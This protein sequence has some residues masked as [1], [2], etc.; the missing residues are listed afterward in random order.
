MSIATMMCILAAP[1][2]GTVLPNGIVLPPVWPPVIDEQTANSAT[3]PYLAS[4]PAVIPIDVGRQ[5]LVDDFLIEHTTL[6]RR[7]HTAELHPASPVLEPGEPWEKAGKWKQ[8][9]GPYAIPFSDGVWFDPADRLFKMWYMGGLL[10]ST[11]LAT[12]TDGIHW[13]RPKLDVKAGTNIVHPGNRDACT[14]WLDLDEP[15]PARRYK[16]F[17]FQKQPRRGLVLHYSADGIHWGGEAAWAGQCH[18]RTTV[19]YNPFRKV[20]ACSIKATLPP[21]PPYKTRVRRYHEGPDPAAAMNWCGYGDPPLWL[22]A[23]RPNLSDPGATERAVVYNLDAVAYESLMLGLFSIIEGPADKAAGRP[24]R[25]QVF[26]G[27]S[28]D[29]FHWYRPCEKPLYGVSERRG[30]WNW[31]NVQSAGGC[32][33]IVGDR[34][35]FYHSGRAGN[36]RLGPEQEFWDADGSTGLA[37]LRRDGF[38]SM[39]A[40][41]TDR[42]LTTRPLRF[43]GAHLFVNAA[44]DGGALRVEVLDADGQAIGPYTRAACEPFTGDSTLA[45]VTWRDAAD[46][47]ALAGQPVRFRFH[48]RRGSLYAFWVSPDASGASHGY[49][50]AGGPGYTGSTD[51]VGKEARRH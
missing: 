39:D 42:T 5:L 19:F 28:R 21:S 16:M 4:P 47:A 7:Y 22:G 29:G 2:A 26:V 30:D 14:V 32:C 1:G 37:V 15:E 10:Y 13:E 23:E 31:G 34:L 18:D 8:Y 43:G 36:A 6:Q 33:L 35:Y 9:T 41:D 50:A 45:V 38:A 51:T 11:C 40:D 17:R 25:N 49:V 20:W 3:P 12:S 24:K 48:L 27:F 46:L 44:I